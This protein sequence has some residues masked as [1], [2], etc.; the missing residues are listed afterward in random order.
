MK[1]NMQ[2]SGRIIILTFLIFKAVYG[3]AQTAGTPVNTL[4]AAEKAAGW[5]LLFDGKTL[6]G[7][8]SYYEADKTKGWTIEDG[9]LKNPKGTGRPRTGGGDI[10]TD[11][12][13]KDFEFS[14]EWNIQ[15][16]G[17]SG[18][19]YLMQERQH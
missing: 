3:Q 4:S 9:C 5:K 10:M 18:V 7:W 13:F 17:N 11:E 15:Q 19:Y 6:N 1:N 8:H 14:W 12:T 16:G 2:L